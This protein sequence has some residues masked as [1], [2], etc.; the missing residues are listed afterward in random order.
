ME[1]T[2]YS[3]GKL[4]LTAEYV[5]LDGA[6]ALAIPTKK[7]Q[8][9]KVSHNGEA[10]NM[11]HW[12]SYTLN[13]D[14]WF[15]DT[16]SISK[17]GIVAATDTKTSAILCEILKAAQQLN[18]L[19]LTEIKERTVTTHLEFPKNWGLGSSSTLISN[20]AQWAQVDPFKLLFNSFKGSGYDIAAAQAKSA[21]LYEV[22][23]EVPKI[24]PSPL[25]WSFKDQLFFVHLNKK[26]DSKEGI[27]AYKARQ[28]KQQFDIAAFSAIS[29]AMLHAA[30]LTDFE[31]LIVEHEEATSSIIG[32]PTV[33]QQYFSSYNGAIKSLGAWGGD[34]VLATGTAK[35]MAYFKEMGYETILPFSEMCL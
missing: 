1:R 26:Q 25:H 16:F 28:A 31:K 19:F 34:F 30:N 22:K 23:N 2:F 15:E 17:H 9:L 35:D 21:F 3:H 11:I 24:V 13:N 33:K 29:E 20:I 7:G 14:C 32:L 8:S 27:S 10:N 4:L 6:T 5:V 18:P 12:M